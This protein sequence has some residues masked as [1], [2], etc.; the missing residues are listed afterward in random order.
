MRKV[1]RKNTDDFQNELFGEYL[2]ILPIVR[3]NEGYIETQAMVYFIQD[4][5]SIGVSARED[6]II[7]SDNRHYYPKALDEDEI[8][9][10]LEDIELD[11]SDLEIDGNIKK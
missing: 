11:P 4:D 6:V 8:I 9:E 3:T 5:G 1:Y 10:N 7:K 2:N